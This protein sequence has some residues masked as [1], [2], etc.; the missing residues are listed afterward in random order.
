VSQTFQTSS[1]NGT[2]RIYFTLESGTPYYRVTRLGGELLKSSRLGFILKDENP[3]AQDFSVE[4]TD[5]KLVNE[6]WTQPWGE[7]KEISNHYSELRIDLKETSVDQ[8]K[9]TV[10]FRVFDDGIGFRYEI[11]EQPNLVNFEIMDELTEFNWTHDHKAWWIPALQWN[12]Y[13]YLYQNSPLSAID[14][15][16][17]PLT[18][19]TSNGL[20]MSIHEAALTDYASTTLVYTVRRC[21]SKIVYSDENTL[22]YDPDYGYARW[23]YYFISYPKPERTQQAW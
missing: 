2:L 1:P 6:T 16:H 14:T 15:V 8:R 20:Y 17:T 4:S 7:K 9:M 5:I 10:I 19:E 21:Q 18:M 11:P 12:R 22:A 3:L 13:E 23:S